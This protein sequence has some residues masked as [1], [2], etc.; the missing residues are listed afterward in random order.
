MSGDYKK[1]NES[2]IIIGA[3]L[4]L[5]VFVL[6]FIFDFFVIGMVVTPIIESFFTFGMWWFFKSMG[7]P[8]ANKVGANIAQYAANLIP[9]IP[10]IVVVFLVKVYI[11][12]HPKIIAAAGK[13]AG[14]AAKI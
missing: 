2:E 9:F 14:A 13:V 8:H 12:N 7:D 10:S 11:H 6:S 1:I 5:G 3:M 4:A